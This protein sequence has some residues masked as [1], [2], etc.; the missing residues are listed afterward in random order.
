MCILII[1]PFDVD[2]PSQAE[3]TTAFDN[4][5]DGFG[6]AIASKDGKDVVIKKG[7][8]TLKHVFNLL[9]TVKE[10]KSKQMILHFRIATEGAIC[11]GNCHPFP[12]SSEEKELKA[13]EIHTD[14]AIAHNGI[15]SVN[16]EEE[17]ERNESIPAGVTL[18]Y[19]NGVQGYYTKVEEDF[20]PFGWNSEDWAAHYNVMGGARTYA[21]R[22]GLSLKYSDTQ[23]FVKEYLAPLRE[24]MK[25][26]AFY[27]LLAA[28]VPGRMAFLDA[29][30]FIYFGDFKEDAGKFYSNDSYKPRISVTTFASSNTY[31]RTQNLNTSAADKNNLKSLGLFV[32]CSV[33]GLFV[34]R[35]SI[36][37]SEDLGVLCESCYKL[38]AE[39]KI[40]TEAQTSS[41]PPGLCC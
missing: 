22:S 37:D 12:L 32:K 14:M 34:P 7:A 5:K 19:K 11:P 41:Y 17:L 31:R 20:V 36:K 39:G 21:Y 28:F 4:N 33:C 8:L 13:T 3:L 24:V 27:N 30:T 10:P 23:I 15:L 26:S 38:N 35:T 29:K 40:D 18:G 16:N 25:V 2:L 1:K 6:M 9:S